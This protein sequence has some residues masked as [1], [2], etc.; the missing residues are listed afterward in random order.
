MVKTPELIS[1]LN[2]SIKYDV[3]HLTRLMR[4]A[5]WDERI[6]LYASIF[7]SAYIL[8]KKQNVKASVDPD[9]C[10]GCLSCVL[11]C[12]STAITAHCVKEED[13]VPAQRTAKQ[14]KRTEGIDDIRYTD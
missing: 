3:K 14:P 12:P 4:D 6:D 2:Y 9:L 1:E 8:R 7:Y 11:V 10:W 13:W 5:D